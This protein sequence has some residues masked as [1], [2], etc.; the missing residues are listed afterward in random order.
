MSSQPYNNFTDLT[1]STV[2]IGGEQGPGG[3]LE[4]RSVRTFIKGLSWRHLAVGCFF[5][6]L[7]AMVIGISV[8]FATKGSTKADAKADKE[9]LPSL[10]RAEPHFA[11]E[12]EFSMV[13]VFFWPWSSELKNTSSEMYEE[14]HIK[15]EYWVDMIFESGSGSSCIKAQVTNMVELNDHIL[16]LF[17]LYLTC[18]DM[19][20]IEVER[21]YDE[22]YTRMQDKPCVANISHNNDINKLHNN[23]TTDPKAPTSISNNICGQS[24]L[25]PAA[26]IVGGDPVNVGEFPWVVMLLNNGE[27]VCGGTIWDYDHILTAAHCIEDL[28]SDKATGLVNTSSLQI[29]AGKWETNLSVNHYEQRVEVASGRIHTGYITHFLGTGND[30]ALLKLATSLHPNQLV[31][32]VCH[33]DADTRLPELGIVAGWGT[34]KAGLRRFPAVLQSVELSLLDLD[35]CHGVFIINYIVNND[36]YFLPNG[37]FCAM[38]DDLDEKDS[39]QGD[40]GRPSLCQPG[41]RVSGA[42][43]NPRGRV[44]R[45]WMR[46]YTQT[47]RVCFRSVLSSLDPRRH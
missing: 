38:D 45:V 16:F 26:K 10:P 5:L 31:M 28:P 12:A 21:L 8:H 19:T 24:Q 43:H 7:L 6:A 36:I 3:S 2:T 20:E 47:G 44:L 4:G 41:N 40:S 34:T 1:G 30:V 29:I 32:K 39:C 15:A 22:G 37:T 13:I 35:E 42:L 33:P 23:T 46:R 9:C 27:F 17:N 18:E 11:E 25:Y 14:T